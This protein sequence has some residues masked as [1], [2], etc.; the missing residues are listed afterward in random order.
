MPTTGLQQL[1]LH[2]VVELPNLRTPNKEFDLG[3]KR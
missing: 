2:A 1:V 3:L